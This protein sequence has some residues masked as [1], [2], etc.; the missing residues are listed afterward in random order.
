[1]NNKALRVQ[2]EYA[3]LKSAL[4]KRETLENFIVRNFKSATFI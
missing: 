4:L 1:M 3:T 2:L